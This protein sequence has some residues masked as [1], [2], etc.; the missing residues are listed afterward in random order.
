YATE[1]GIAT[2]AEVA[3]RL[4][5]D[6]STLFVAVERYRALRPDL[7]NIGSLHDSGPVLRRGLTLPHSQPQTCLEGTV[8]L[9]PA[10]KAVPSLLYPSA[11]SYGRADCRHVRRIPIEEAPRLL[12]PVA[13]V[14]HSDARRARDAHAA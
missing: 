7:F 9:L 1:R 10:W 2:L 6:P 8:P 3:R 12:R 13:C 5:R 4:E 14:V 11:L